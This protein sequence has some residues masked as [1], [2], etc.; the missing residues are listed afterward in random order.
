MLNFFLYGYDSIVMVATMWNQQNFN[1]FEATSPAHPVA[2]VSERDH[3]AMGW[4]YS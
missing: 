1:Q 4:D 3:I 2:I